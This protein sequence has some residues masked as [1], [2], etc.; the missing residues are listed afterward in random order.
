MTDPASKPD[1]PKGYGLR[2]ALRVLTRRLEQRE[3]IDESELDANIRF[4]KAVRDDETCDARSRL[5]AA[6]FIQK[7]ADQA[8][9][10]A[11]HLDDKERASKHEVDV[12][13]KLYEGFD[14]AQVGKAV[15]S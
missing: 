5:R 8:L 15:A 11:K 13:P 3:K 10:I 4:A 14:P 6:E 2:S 9:E 12:V 1:A 7:V